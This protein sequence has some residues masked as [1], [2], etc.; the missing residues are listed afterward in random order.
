V[1]RGTPTPSSPKRLDGGPSGPQRPASSRALYAVG[2]AYLKLAGWTTSGELPPSAK[3]VLIAAPHTSGWDLPYM[4]A[5]AWVYG[6]ELS[7]LGKHTLFAGWRGPFMR[8]LG[9][10]PVDRRAPHGL[11]AGVVAQLDA[12]DGM[13]LAIA[14][15][16][17]R[18]SGGR[19]R[20]GFYHIANDARVP[21]IC[22]F[23]DY[24]RK[25][26]GVGPSFVPSGDVRADMDRI[27]AFYRGITGRYPD[28]VHTI[29]LREELAAP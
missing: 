17:T 5:V 29:E 16:G 27:R 13:I 9:G 11:V 18:T 14:P 22:G 6:L 12:S 21:I 2:A 25:V 20:S 26:G 28:V 4:L 15:A 23:L 8:W 10:V 19:W 7:W 3:G 24:G 1:P